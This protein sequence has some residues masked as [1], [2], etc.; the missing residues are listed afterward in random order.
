MLADT[1][2]LGASPDNLDYVK[3][4]PDKDK[5]A[6][7]VRGLTPAAARGF[8]VSHTQDKSLRRRSVARL[9][10]TDV[11]PNSEVG[12]TNVSSLYIVLDRPAVKTAADVEKMR[13]RLLTFISTPAMFDA[14]VSGES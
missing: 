3:Q 2:T 7:G 10:D 13:K 11:D 9:D 1:L 14:W 5:S 8:N 4:Y 6:Y 12:K